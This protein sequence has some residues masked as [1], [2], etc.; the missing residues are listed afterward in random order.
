MQFENPPSTFTAAGSAIPSTAS[1]VSHQPTPFYIDN[2]LGPSTQ[3]NNDASSNSSTPAGS[4]NGLANDQDPARLSLLSSASPNM[5]IN[6]MQPDM[7]PQQQPGQCLQSQTAMA[8]SQLHVLQPTTSPYIVQSNSSSDSSSLPAFLA[9]SS[10]NVSRHSQP[11][12]RPIVPTPIQAVPP[13]H[14]VGYPASGGSYSRPSG[15]Y[16]PPPGLHSPYTPSPMQY[17]PG[18]YGGPPAPP[19]GTLYPYPR[20]DYTSWFLDRQAAFSKGNL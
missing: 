17:G 19:H 9:P 6:M 11:P 2:I 3:T 14:P 12:T 10:P 15:I 18:H 16:D 13:S 1:Y 7:L 4:H 5:H 8:D 20:H